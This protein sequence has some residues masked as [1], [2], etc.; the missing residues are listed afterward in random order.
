MIADWGGDPAGLAAAEVLAEAGARVTLCVA[1]VALG[2][3][4]HQYRRNLALRRL[5]PAPAW[6][7]SAH[8]EL[9]RARGGVTFRNTFAPELGAVLEADLL[10]LALGRVLED[11]GP[12]PPPQ[13]SRSVR[14][15]LPLAEIAR[16]SDPRGH[17]LGPAFADPDLDGQDSA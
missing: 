4:L 7:V 3:S 14:L 13:G 8:L 10:V 6:S 9:V 17:A 1:S 16:G 12:E 2:E 15:G 5:Y 11:L